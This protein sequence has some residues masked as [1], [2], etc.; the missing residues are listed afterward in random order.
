[1]KKMKWWMWLDL[2]I[3][4]VT[5]LI[6]AG[7]WFTSVKTV[8][9]YSVSEE[10]FGNP[11][12]G[13][14]PCAWYEEVE[15]DVTLLYMDITWAELEPEEGQYA[16][17][18][19]ETKNQLERWR[20]EGKHIVLRFVCDVPGS[21]MHM[22]I[23]QWL[24]EKTGQSGTWYNN[25][26]GQGYAPDYDNTEFI[27][28]HAKAVKALGERF[29]QD[30]L[31]SYVE[32]GSLGHWGEW[33]VNFSTGIKRLPEE[34]V[35]EQYVSPWAEAFPEAFLLFRRSFSH[36]ERHGAGLYNDMAG[37]LEET[38]A[39]LNE[40]A[41]GGDLSQTGETGVMAAMPDF[42]QNAPSGGEF[43]SALS[44]EEMLDT[45]LSRTVAL[46]RES[47]TT[48]LG[49]KTASTDYPEG[50]AEVLKNMGYRLWIPQ[51][52]M[53]RSFDS[54]TLELTWANAGVAPFYKNWPVWLIVEDSEG[55][56]V[57]KEQTG[58]EL[59]S[60]LPDKKVTTRTKLQT[61]HLY[62][63]AGQEYKISVGIEDPMTEQYC[64]RL[65]MKCTVT[66]GKN[67]L[68]E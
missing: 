10:S 17:E 58:L 29:V 54:T 65:A 2:G 41:Q 33:H 32:L 40:I 22:D 51:V 52:V 67:Y 64:V 60:V 57:E 27:A 25:A 48:F 68:W 55:N 66:D 56:I 31:I 43:T 19:I 63:Q 34:K 5:L 4:V 49:P 14:A 26:L 12:M 45:Q 21:E 24:Y 1:M 18:T 30:G 46:V 39:W 42:W 50:Y 47:H 6:L 61:K 16:W 38:K 35:R 44:M 9:K 3:A 11:L 8:K 20:Q 15:D 13:Y 28:Y 37:E 59:S 23:P 7:V 53:T 62:A 36:A